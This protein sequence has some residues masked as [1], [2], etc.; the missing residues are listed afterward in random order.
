MRP[1]SLVWRR[2]RFGEFTAGNAPPAPAKSGR[3]QHPRRNTHVNI[4]QSVADRP[5]V[6][7]D[8]P[9]LIVDLD[10]MDRNIARMSRR[11]IEEAGLQWRPHMKCPKIPAIAHRMI[12]AGA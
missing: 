4:Y 2:W 1:G 9:A 11:I 6:Q 12:A 10:K 8:T 7:L 3:H 5:K